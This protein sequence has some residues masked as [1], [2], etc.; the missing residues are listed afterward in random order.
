M[1]KCWNF[2]TRKPKSFWEYCLWIILTLTI[3][4]IWNTIWLY[5][6]NKFSVNN[7][8]E[9]AS[10]KVLWIL[11]Y[12]PLM[13][14]FVFRFMPITVTKI[15]ISEFSKWP[16]FF[17]MLNVIVASSI[18]FALAHFDWPRCL[19]FQGVGGLLFSLLFL[20][21]VNDEK[22]TEN[23]LNGAVL[24]AFAAVA[25]V[26]SLHNLFVLLGFYFFCIGI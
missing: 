10:L 4:F 22:S 8:A 2:I 12:A 23:I 7:M 24:R 17:I 13:E 9:M 5:H 6:F 14:E 25:S 18:L 1:G 11:I 26:H 21:C 3:D 15:I 20:K 16:K 19:L